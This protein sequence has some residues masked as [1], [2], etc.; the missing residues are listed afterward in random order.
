MSSR[1]PK[2]SLVENL[3]RIGVE[4]NAKTSPPEGSNGGTKRSHERK[5]IMAKNK[6]LNKKL[7]HERIAE[8]DQ[9]PRKCMFG[10]N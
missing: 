4:N 8:F 6:C 7:A 1:Q 10:D 5:A 3:G 2:P 9:H